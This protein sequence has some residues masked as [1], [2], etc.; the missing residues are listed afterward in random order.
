M[1]Q[2]NPTYELFLYSPRLTIDDFQRQI[3]EA[4]RHNFAVISSSLGFSSQ[5]LAY[6]TSFRVATVIDFPYGTSTFH[7]KLHEVI[8]A[9]NLG[10]DIID[11]T[12]NQ[13]EAFNNNWKNIIKELNALKYLNA[14]IKKEIRLVIDFNLYSNEN[15]VSLA[16]ICDKI[17]MRTII[18]ST[19]LNI[20]DYLDN[21]TV[22]A[23]L[24]KF[25]LTPVF[26]LYNHH[27]GHII[28][29]ETAGITNIRL[30]NVKRMG[31]M[32]ILD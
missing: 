11:F 9:S 31:S 21:L 17:G 24:K 1:A 19:G 30:L 26:T 5:I 7:N 18:T 10:V 32:S 27:K 23:Q 25:G 14:T 3:F 28:D 2:T 6:Q 22:A 16:K 15:L 20:D 12:L 8:E 4:V 13:Y 29:L